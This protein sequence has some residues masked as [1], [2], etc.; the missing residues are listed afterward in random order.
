MFKKIQLVVVAIG[1]S[2]MVM[3]QNTDTTTVAK[4]TIWRVG[5]AFG[6]KFNQVA[7]TNWTAGGQNSLAW[8][9]T[10]DFTA[11]YAKDKWKWDNI[12]HLGYGIS[13]QG[14]DPLNKTDDQI[15]LNT[16]LGY[17]LKGPWYATLS[18]NFRTQFVNGYDLP[19]DSVVISTFMAP[20]Y[21]VA[22]L[23][24]EFKPNDDFVFSTSPI[25]NKTTFVMDDLLAAQGAYGVDSSSNVRVEFGIFLSLFYKKEIV[26]NVTFT[27]L[28]TMFGNYEDLAVWDVNWDLILDFKINS[29]LEANLTTNLIYDQDIAIPVDRTGD[30]IKESVGPRIQFRQAL[31]IG[32]TAKF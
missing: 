28:Y 5:G 29:F 11:N 26:K 14:E 15:L 27:T 30:G 3:A 20:G 13:K 1:L 32:F 18:A 19:N 7:L 21:L 24:I 9:A 16:N 10:F 6:F 25:S 17:E 31:G 4:D 22:G 2:T 23:G 12:V 8:N